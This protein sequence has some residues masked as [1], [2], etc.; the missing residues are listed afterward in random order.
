MYHS[1]RPFTYARPSVLDYTVEDTRLV[2]RALGRTLFR[3]TDF[4]CPGSQCPST[5]VKGHNVPPRRPER[6]P[7][8]PRTVGECERAPNYKV[9]CYSRPRLKSLSPPFRDWSKLST[10]LSGFWVL[11]PRDD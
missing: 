8:G 5:T 3:R 4:E 9:S 1:L 10:P 11:V 7:G 6:T 2:A